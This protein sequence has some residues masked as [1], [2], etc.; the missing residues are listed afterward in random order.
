LLALTIKNFAFIFIFP[1]VQWIPLPKILVLVFLI[2]DPYS[3][4]FSYLLALTNKNFVF[5][6]IFPWVQWITLQISLVFFVS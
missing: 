5:I 2:P 3:P 1:W 6:F 4:L